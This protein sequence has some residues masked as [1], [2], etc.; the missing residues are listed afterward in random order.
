MAILIYVLAVIIALAGVFFLF[1]TPV[2][3]I[4]F[5]IL[6]VLIFIWQK[7]KKPSK[8]AVSTVAEPEELE[9]D[10]ET[11]KVAGITHYTK[12]VLSLGTRNPQYD[13]KIADIKADGLEGD[14]IYEYDFYP[15][16]A[17]L[18][19]EP[20]NK[21][22]PNAI[23]V[24]VDGKI[25]GY[26]KAESTAHVKN[27]MEEN[28]IRSI[29][30]NIVGGSYKKYDPEENRIIKTFLNYGAKLTFFLNAEK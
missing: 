9:K 24:Y 7:K 17:T 22:D 8:A 13:Y 19:P 29:T 6:G 12:N 30:C 1:V 26:I 4:I 23:A 14:E 3:G 15:M 28:R 5:I 25:I 11:H 10:R 27:L 21:Y 20:E 16:S 18:V 2:A